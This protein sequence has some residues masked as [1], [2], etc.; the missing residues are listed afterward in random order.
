MWVKYNDQLINLDKVELIM[1][2]E[3]MIKVFITGDEFPYLLEY[4]S[5]ALAERAFS[6]LQTELKVTGL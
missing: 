3:S 4:E 5:E 6:V 1:L 2:D